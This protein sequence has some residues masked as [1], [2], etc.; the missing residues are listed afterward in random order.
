MLQ[1]HTASRKK[2]PSPL[3]NIDTTTPD[4]TPVNQIQTKLN[5]GS[6]EK[7]DGKETP[8]FYQQKLT[9]AVDPQ[10][11]AQLTIAIA[12]LIHSCGLPFSLASHHKFHRVLSLAKFVTKKYVPPG[13]NKVAG[14]LLDLNY[15]IYIKNTLE[16][17][18]KEADVYG[19][20][21]FGF[22]RYS[23]EITTHQYTCFVSA[24]SSRMFENR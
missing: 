20:T 23:Q 22:C 16:L 24:S 15:E 11:E 14:E 10:A 6:Q 13:R 4:G 9:D 19:I 18:L 17:L 1:M 8:R 2:K 7:N 12:D 21:F 5:S 3:T